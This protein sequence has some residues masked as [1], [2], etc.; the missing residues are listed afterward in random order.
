MLSIVYLVYSH[1][2]PTPQSHPSYGN[3]KTKKNRVLPLK[4]DHPYDKWVRF[5]ERIQENIIKPEALIKGIAE[6]LR[7][8]LPKD[9]SH[10]Q[11]FPKFELSEQTS[12]EQT[13]QRRFMVPS[14]SDTKNDLY[15]EIASPFLIPNKRLLDIQYYNRKDGHN[16]K[17]WQFYRSRR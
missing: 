2:F 12:C 9:K 4:K 13:P 3:A 16:F 6:V 15:G 1:K 11:V 7:K 8:I 14:N 17:N 5:R 10:Q